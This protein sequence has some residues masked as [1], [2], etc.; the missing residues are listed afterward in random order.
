ML[1]SG[2][3]RKAW[4]TQ[5]RAG[6]FQ[7]CGTVR[8]VAFNGRGLVK[9]RSRPTRVEANAVRCTASTCWEAVSMDCERPNKEDMDWIPCHFGSSCWLI[10]L[11]LPNSGS[12]WVSHGCF[13]SPAN[14]LRHS[15]EAVLR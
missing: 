14:R 10:A 3:C 4:R 13:W 2:A 11:D 5:E 1:P 7:A 12:T 6:D 8:L 15:F 9:G